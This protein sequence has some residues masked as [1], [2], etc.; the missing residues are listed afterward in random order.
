MASLVYYGHF[1]HRQSWADGISH[2]GRAYTRPCYAV[3][4]SLPRIRA[5]GRSKVCLQLTATLYHADLNWFANHC[6][7]FPEMS[8]G[9]WPLKHPP[10]FGGM[11][12]K[13]TPGWKHS[14]GRT[15]SFPRPPNVLPHLVLVSTF[16]CCPCTPHLYPHT[17][18][19]FTVSHLFLPLPFLNP[20][21]KVKLFQKALSCPHKPERILASELL[22]PNNSLCSRSTFHTQ[23]CE[24]CPWT[25]KDVQ[26]LCQPYTSHSS[27]ICILV[28][29]PHSPTNSHPYLCS[30]QC[31]PNR[32]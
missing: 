17:V 22:S 5:L 4:V 15:S 18:F 30:Q 19:F 12:S 21:P 27:I 24:M 9:S 31:L 29:W 28:L 11:S 26:V 23:L 32:A 25:G 16:S 6:F 13:A 3:L 1:C 8:W 20:S 14:N 2:I 10:A 7:L